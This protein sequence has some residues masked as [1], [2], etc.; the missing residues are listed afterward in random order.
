MKPG[1]FYKAIR[2]GRNGLFFSLSQNETAKGLYLN[3]FVFQGIHHQ[4]D[5]VLYTCFADQ[6]GLMSFNRSQTDKKL[7]GN[8]RI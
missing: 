7:V 1:Y 2:A 3:Q 6:V 4:A 8:L 5:G